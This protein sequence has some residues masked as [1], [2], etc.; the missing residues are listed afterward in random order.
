MGDFR[1]E[2]AARRPH[3]LTLT[4]GRLMP[5]PARRTAPLLLSAALATVFAL[6]GCSAGSAGGSTPAGSTPPVASP[7]PTPT[8]AGTAVGVTCTD[9]FAG[10]DVAAAL[11]GYALKASFTAPEGSS[12]ALAARIDGVAC[13]LTS[14]TGPISVGL[15]KPDAASSAALQKA[16]TATGSPVTGFGPDV[17][18]TFDEMTGQED[19]FT[20]TGVWISVQSSGFTNPEV[21]R[22]LLQFITQ[23]LPSG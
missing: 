5:H 15:S 9:V 12:A 3:P 11:P 19:L 21:A 18:A 22:P 13:G 14:P 7:T 8:Y 17:T 10:G 1:L 2:A 20:A 6:A 16:R 23:A 4:D